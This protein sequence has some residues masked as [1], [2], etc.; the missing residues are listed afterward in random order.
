MEK[1]E[2]RLPD[3]SR[4]AVWASYYQSGNRDTLVPRGKS[5]HYWVSL[6]HS[7]QVVR[8]GRTFLR[9]NAIELSK[10][11]KHPHHHIRLNTEFRSDLEWW[12]L[13][14]PRWN[15]VG[16]LTSLYSRPHT[17]SVTSDAS[18]SWGCGAFSSAN[19]WYQLPLPVEWANV[20]ITVKELLP[21]V[22]SCALW[23]AQMGRGVGTSIHR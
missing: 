12:I 7:C 1:L 21:V 10:V 16:M 2:V 23:G 18:G 13:F 9:P 5:C 3:D 6:H 19:Q 15:G 22:I 14:L 8:P 17:V 11:V 20:H 4:C